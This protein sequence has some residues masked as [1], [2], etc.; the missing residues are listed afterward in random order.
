MYFISLTKTRDDDMGN[1]KKIVEL[2]DFIELF[3]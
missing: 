1:E 3:N 2:N